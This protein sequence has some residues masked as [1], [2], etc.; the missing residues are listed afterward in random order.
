MRK[1]ILCG[2][3]LIAAVP[4][5]AQQPAGNDVRYQQCVALVN[6]KPDDAF[7]Q[8]LEWRDHG[9]GLA[10]E[11]CAA[12]AEL[13]LKEPADAAVRLDRI[14]HSQEAGD[15]GMRAELLDQSG[16][17]WLLAGQPEDAEASFSAALSLTPADVDVLIDRSR[18]RAMRKDWAGAESDLTRAYDFNKSNPEVLVLRASARG[19]Q[20]RNAD[21]K[22]DIDAA[23][24]VDPNFPDALVERGAYRMRTGDRAGAR[25]DWLQVIARAPNTGAADSARKYIEDMEVNPQANVAQPAQE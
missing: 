10:A 16:N 6:K 12:L 14:A 5:S 24:A 20:G 15:A 4:V 18:A 23:L 1:T 7:E 3:A 25:A 2:L 21:A 13:A 8:A 22:A 11:H 9:G 17:A 19:A